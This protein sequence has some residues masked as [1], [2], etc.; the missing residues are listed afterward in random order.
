MVRTVLN[1]DKSKTKRESVDF[2]RARHP[3]SRGR[4]R[5]NRLFF[6]QCTYIVLFGLEDFG[7][8][9]FIVF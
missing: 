8:V 6:V 5:I 2:E 3:V 9:V 7:V 1:I 4:R